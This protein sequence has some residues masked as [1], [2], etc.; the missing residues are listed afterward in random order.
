MGTI[1]VRVTNSYGRQL[2]YPVCK[3]ADEFAGIAGT[4]TLGTE[5]IAAIKALGFE[6]Q[7]QAQTI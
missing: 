4:K 6:I 5:T 7:I 3:A 2:V 1:T